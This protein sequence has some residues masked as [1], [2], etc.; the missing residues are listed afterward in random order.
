MIF[1]SG[2]GGQYIMVIKEL[3]LVA[4]LTGNSYNSPKSKPP[5]EIL[6]KYILASLQKGKYDNQ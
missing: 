2:N 4:V 1:A 6:V 5:F 3:N